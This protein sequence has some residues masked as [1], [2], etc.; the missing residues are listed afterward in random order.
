M[1]TLDLIKDLYDRVDDNLYAPERK[2]DPFMDS[3]ERMEKVN[4]CQLLRL[5][6]EDY[7]DV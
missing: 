6:I 7:E 5:I 3:I 2:Y 1:N 4:L